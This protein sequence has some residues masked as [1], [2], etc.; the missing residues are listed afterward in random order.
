MTSSWWSWIL[1]LSTFPS[2]I[3]FF[4]IVT[5]FDSLLHN[6]L[7]A[8]IAL[9]NTVPGKFSGMDHNRF[10]TL[11]KYSNSS[12]FSSPSGT[13]KSTLQVILKVIFFINI[14]ACVVSFPSSSLIISKFFVSFL[15]IYM[16]L[17]YTNI[18]SNN[19]KQ[20]IMHLCEWKN[21]WIIYYIVI[22]IL[23]NYICSW[24]CTYV[25][26]VQKRILSKYIVSSRVK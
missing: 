24:T 14:T 9:W 5:R 6:L 19:K 1:L 8:L 10:K 15:A 16:L 4:L 17:Y 23:K 3:C 22:I 2:S 18:S 12:S 7:R 26:M 13:P 25:H 11:Q 21:Y 20:Y